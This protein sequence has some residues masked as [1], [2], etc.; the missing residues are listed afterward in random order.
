MTSPSLN[1]REVNEIHK[2]SDKD[3]SKESQHHTLGVDPYQASPGNHTHDG[4][5]SKILS[6]LA[7][8]VHSHNAPDVNSNPTAGL[9]A[10]NVQ[11]ALEELSV[12][13]SNAATAAG[14]SLTPVGGVAATNVQAAIQELDTEKAAA[15][16]GH[17]AT[18]TP[19]TPVGAVAATN[20]QAAI[21][22]LDTEKLAKSAMPYNVTGSRGG[23]A[24]LASLLTQ[25][26]TAGI[27]TDSTTA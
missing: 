26:A 16:T 20:V 27:I 3:S 11:G 23:N 14:T 5:D 25:L 2:L 17:T 6:S 21:Q 15:H 18:N 12:E 24:A 4:R 22:E 10:T 13:V 9:V 8:S 7:T 19:F 1:P